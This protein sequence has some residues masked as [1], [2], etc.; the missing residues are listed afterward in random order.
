LK[1]VEITLNKQ[2]GFIP[3]VLVWMLGT[4]MVFNALGNS[5]A[6]MA[7]GP[8]VSAAKSVDLFPDKAHIRYAR[9]FSIEYHGTYKRLEVFTP[10]PKAKE[11]FV[12]ILVARG[13]TPPSDLPRGATVIQIPV[14]RIAVYAVIWLAFFPMLHIENSVVG[15]AG[16]NT[17]CTPEIV[18][19]IRQGRIEEIGTGGRG[20]LGPINMER[21]ILLKPE[22]VMVYG[23]GVPELD[24]APKLLEAGFKPVINASYMEATPL[25]HAEW[26]KFIAAFFNKEA[27][28]ERVFDDIVLR[29]EALAEKTR[30]VSRRPTVVCGV[31]RR[32]IWYMPGG[33][34]YAARR[35]VDA[36]ADY[37][38]GEDTT[39]GA[40]VPLAI[41][42]VFDRARDAEFWLDTTMCRSLVEL[43]GVDDRYGLFSSFRAGKVFNNDARSTPEGGNDF[44]ETGMARPDLVLADLISIFHPEL[45]PDHQRI[46]YRKLPSRTEGQQ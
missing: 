15:L 39:P 34:S 45:I 28:A 29:Y 30:T 26:I 27:E 44:W 38:W 4:S 23:T 22:T 21:L 42:S 17:A 24:Q 40:M 36:G 46:W 16:C 9:C 3:V 18:S 43:R 5:Y 6:A 20:M 10:W 41:E 14:Q 11:S 32:G 25:G 37:L 13:H 33:A 8:S 7:G 2:W 35:L 31:G 19:L 12:F 1:R